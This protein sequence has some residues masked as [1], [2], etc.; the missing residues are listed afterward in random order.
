MRQNFRDVSATHGEIDTDSYPDEKL[1]DKK[2]RRSVRERAGPGAR[3]NY[4]HVD[5]HQSFAAKAIRDGPAKSGPENSTQD[6][7]RTNKADYP[8]CDMKLSDDEG[9]R[10]AESKNGE[11]IK[12]RPSGREHPKPSLDGF[13]RRLIQ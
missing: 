8:G 10:D 9:H 7:S 4:Y 3:A 11:A 13:Q 1:A 5:E 12:Q 2:H 6:Q